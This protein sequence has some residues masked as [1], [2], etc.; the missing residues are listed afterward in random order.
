MRR[1]ISYPDL[2][3]LEPEILCCSMFVLTPWIGNQIG[4]TPLTR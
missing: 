3:T 1:L 2:N 4:F